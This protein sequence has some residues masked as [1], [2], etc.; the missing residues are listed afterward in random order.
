[1]GTDI[2]IAI[3]VR[4]PGGPWTSV[5]YHTA[6]YD[7]EKEEGKKPV[8]RIPVAPDNFRSRNY[9]LFG[10]LADVRNGTGFAGVVTGSPWPTIAPQRGFPEGYA[11]EDEPEDAGYADEGP[12][13]MGDHSF[14]WVGLEE[15]KSYRWDEVTHTAKGLV[16]AGD[17]EKLMPGEVP[18]SYCGAVWGPATKVYDI[19][20][21][22]VAKKEGSLGAPDKTFV[23]M[24]WQETAREATGDWPGQVIPW[25]EEVAAGRELRLVLGFD[26]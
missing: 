10:I 5:K 11:Q 23:R 20:D 12:R 19:P 21:Y 1:M 17:Y 18:T 16:E 24:Y 13:W 9:A 6:L 15:L 14:T 22:E 25:L 26:S 2:H 8:P 4:E 7:F 3:Q